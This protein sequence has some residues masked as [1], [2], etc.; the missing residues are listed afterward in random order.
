MAQEDNPWIPIDDAGIDDSKRY[1]V[2]WRD[3]SVSVVYGGG[4]FTSNPV[5]IR[6]YSP[7]PYKPP[8][9][10]RLDTYVTRESRYV[11][12]IGGITHI[13]EVLP[14]D[15]SPEAIERVVFEMRSFVQLG[16]G[17]IPETLAKWADRLEG[18]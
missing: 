16:N 4:V 15:P 11:L 2:T 12:R 18:K 5:A 14:G 9:T 6:E 17:A 1:E 10:E 13:R 7:E 3:G 8:K